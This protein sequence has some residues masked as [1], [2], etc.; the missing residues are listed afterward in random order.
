MAIIKDR[1]RRTAFGADA[2]VRRGVGWGGKGS[3]HSS[4]RKYRGWR[5]R[6]EYSIDWRRGCTNGK[7]GRIAPHQG[8][9]ECER[10]RLLVKFASGWSL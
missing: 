3:V 7:G 9:R 10:R 2:K 8:E 4:V 1:L 6:V 5:R